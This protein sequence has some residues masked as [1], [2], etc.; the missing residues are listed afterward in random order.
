MK[1][2]PFQLLLKFCCTTLSRIKCYIKTKW[3]QNPVNSFRFSLLFLLLNCS[4]KLTL[5]AKVFRFMTKPFCNEVGM[6][7][8]SVFTPHF[9]FLSSS[10]T[11]CVI[12]PHTPTMFLLLL[13]L[14]LPLLNGSKLRGSID[15]FC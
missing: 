12:C 4:E 7:Q 2:C 15:L 13:W 14:L 3:K 9:N 1:C 11:I 6:N 8:V 5:S 10:N